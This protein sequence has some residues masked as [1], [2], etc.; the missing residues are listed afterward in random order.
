MNEERFPAVAC[1]AKQLLCIPG[2][3]VP[4][5]QVFNSCGI[6]VNKL[7][8]CLSSEN[9]NMIIFLSKNGMLPSACSAQASLPNTGTSKEETDELGECSRPRGEIDMEMVLEEEVPALPD[10]DH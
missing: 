5:E 9:I 7:R 10:L 6:L 8:C 4:Y 3:S 1:Q 2:T